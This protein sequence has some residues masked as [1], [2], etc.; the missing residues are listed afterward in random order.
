MRLGGLGELRF[1]HHILA[2]A[3]V[4]QSWR[5]LLERGHVP[6]ADNGCGDLYCW[7]RTEVAEPV[8]RFADITY[9]NT[10]EGW[11]YLA[12]LIDVCTRRC[13]GWQTGET[14]AAELVT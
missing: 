11:L 6:F 1:Q 3:E 8:V 2:P 10:G 14:L 5:S 4:L 12:A 9:I 7:P 13:V